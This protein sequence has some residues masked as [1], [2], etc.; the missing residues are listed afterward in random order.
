MRKLERVCAVFMPERSVIMKVKA[1][2][3]VG[4]F[5]INTDNSGV[6]E[7]HLTGEKEGCYVKF[8]TISPE[9]TSKNIRLNFDIRDLE[10]LTFSRSEN[11]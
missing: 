9:K 7:I 5:E 4:G 1:E 3:K 2:I 11:Y 6:H 10:R 8:Q